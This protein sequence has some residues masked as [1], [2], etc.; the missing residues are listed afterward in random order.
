M[1][2]YTARTRFGEIVAEFVPP[3]SHRGPQN[4][5]AIVCTGMPSTPPRGAILEFLS[6][7]GF[8]AFGMRYRGTWESG[9]K[10]LKISPE[11]DVQKVIDG[12]A[13]GFDDAYTG[14]RYRIKSPEVHLFGSSFGGP[15]VILSSRDRRVRKVVALSPVVDWQAKSSESIE[16]AEKFIKRAFGDAIRFDHKDW[17]KLKSGK[18]YNPVAAIRHIDGKKMI[19]FQ[20]KDDL[21][22]RFKP[23]EKFAKEVGAT[24]V[25]F[26]RG[27]HFSS[28]AITKPAVWK[29]IRGFVSR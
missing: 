16:A 20:A 11:K 8:W 24:F 1:K 29:K 3:A 10:F 25:L 4:R 19:I 23:S 12:L 22:T 28:A 26:A 7:K 5:V 6:K 13:R 9:G 27:G 18:F 2:R 14:K 15:A 17:M 21:L